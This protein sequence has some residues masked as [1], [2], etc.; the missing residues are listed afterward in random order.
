MDNNKFAIMTKGLGKKFKKDFF[1]GNFALQNRLEYMVR[2]PI[3][4]FKET[5]FGNNPNG[6]VI[7]NDKYFWA[8][9]DVSF[10]IK[11]G[12]T[13]GIIGHNG[14][15]K[16]VLLKILSQITKPS[17]GTAEIRGRC[18]SMLEV[19]TGFHWELTGRENIFMSAAI[20]GLKKDYINEKFEELVELSG[21]RPFLDTP[22]K[23]YSSGMRVRLGFALATQLN[24]EILILDEILAVGDKSFRAQCVEY[25]RKLKKEGQTILIVSHNMKTIRELCD[26]VLWFEKG[27]LVT[28]GPTKEILDDYEKITNFHGVSK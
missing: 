7:Q 5:N 9:K 21:V 23:R 27:R 10:E 11:F 6:H 24:P 18:N 15:G 20:L 13:V 14:A 4:K 12:E 16:S 28:Q 17:E 25:L 22:V 3:G 2:K 1:R 19:D 8:L 26:R